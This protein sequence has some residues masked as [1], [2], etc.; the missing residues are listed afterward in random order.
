MDCLTMADAP[1]GFNDSQYLEETKRRIA[2]RVRITLTG[3]HECSLSVNSEGYST[4]SFQARM[5]RT[6]RLLW[7][8]EYGDIPDGLV[9]DHVCRNRTCCNLDHL[10]LVTNLENIARGSYVRLRSRATVC[11]KGHDLVAGRCL[12]CRGQRQRERRANP[13]YRA[14]RNADSINL[15]ARVAPYVKGTVLQSAGLA[16]LVASLMFSRGVIG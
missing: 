14:K 1:A 5:W 16:C 8:I 2:E 10:E 15:S 13:V 11:G 12:T 6:H 7:I 4:I 9:I 3:C